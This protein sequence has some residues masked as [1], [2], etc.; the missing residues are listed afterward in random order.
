MSGRKRER[1]RGKLGGRGRKKERK[2]GKVVE[3]KREDSSEIEIE[4]KSECLRQGK[5]G[6]GR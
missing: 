5:R 2:N 6:K 4:R 3:K 1:E